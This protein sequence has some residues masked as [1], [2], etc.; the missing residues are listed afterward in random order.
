[1]ERPVFFRGGMDCGGVLPNHFVLQWHI[2]ERCNLAAA[3]AIRKS[4]PAADLSRAGFAEVL[5][6]FQDLMERAFARK[7]G[8]GARAYPT[9]PAGSRSRAPTSW[10]C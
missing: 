2:T 8:R 1:M 6:Q 7:G 5:R 9:S 4:P 10:S 3:T